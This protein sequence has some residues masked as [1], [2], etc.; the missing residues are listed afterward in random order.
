MPKE[1]PKFRYAE[2]FLR[3]LDELG[4]EVDDIGE[5]VKQ[6]QRQLAS[7]ISKASEVR[8]SLVFDVSPSDPADQRKTI[9]RLKTRIDPDIQKVEVPN[10]KKLQ[11]QYNLAEE[12][13][14][15]YKTVE[16]METQLGLQF[17]DRRG[18][19]YT[20]TINA[21][22]AMKAKIADHLKTC[23]Q[24]LNDVADK[25]VP[26][27]FK[28]YVEAVTAL[29]DEYVIFK[30]SSSFMYASVTPEG[31]LVFTAYL[32]LLDAI[33]DE[34]EIAPHLYLSIQ[35]VVSDT[36]SIRVDLNHE[37]DVPNKLLGSGELV[38]SVGEAAKAISDML[39]IENF[40]SALGVVPLALQ[41]KVD[42]ARLSSEMFS[43]RDLIEKVTV[44]EQTIAFK[45]RPQADSP[46]MVKAVSYQIYKEL[47]ELLKT[48]SVRLT[49]KYSKKDGSDVIVFNI[50][51]TAK[52]GE[53]NTYDLEFLRDKF[54]LSSQ[55]LKRIAN[56]INQG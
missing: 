1:L 24:F 4:R 23:L 25:H 33:N 50:V 27:Q 17:S 7:L 53:L 20:A 2:D 47:K 44:D 22:A 34:G 26:K 39:E 5:L 12:L 32:V 29:V 56:I 38:G 11:S 30:D 41:L 46:E 35:W 3:Y 9:R 42:P 19:T 43:Y 14:E 45:L 16:S 18:E 28:K 6:R 55:A 37:Y 54:G 51:Q 31:D 8:A 52:G 10:I 49:M 40:S 48:K 13:H 36:P 21:L 15:K